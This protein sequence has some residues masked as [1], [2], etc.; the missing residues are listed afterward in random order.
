VILP[1]PSRIRTG[2]VFALLKEEHS[3]NIQGTYLK[4]LGY[5]IPCPMTLNVLRPKVFP[6]DFKKLEDAFTQ[7]TK[8]PGF[9]NG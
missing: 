7:A 1:L 6:R 2:Q 3:A 4:G 5:D 8:E 9:I